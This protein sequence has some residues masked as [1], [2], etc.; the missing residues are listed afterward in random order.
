MSLTPKDPNY[1]E[2]A[3][4]DYI[5]K[6]LGNKQIVELR[7]RLFP[8]IPPIPRKDAEAFLIDQIE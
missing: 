3:Y 5:V 7:Y 8:G 2:P 4:V 1:F 6:E